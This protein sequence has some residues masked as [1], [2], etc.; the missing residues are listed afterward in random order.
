MAK[1]DR[2]P[3][4]A[5]EF[6]RMR[7][8]VGVLMGERG[9]DR[10]ARM[11]DLR[12]AIDTLARRIGTTSGGNL[13]MSPLANTPYPTEEQ[14]AVKLATDVQAF[15]Y[16]SG[17]NL[18]TSGS[19]STQ[20]TFTA[21]VTGLRFPY[22]TWLVT[23]VDG[24]ESIVQASAS[25]E[26]VFTPPSSVSGPG[27]MTVRVIVSLDKGD[28]TPLA[29]DFMSV[30]LLREGTGVGAITM[31]LS[32]QAHVCPSA[33]D[34]SGVILTGSGT[35]LF[36]WS[37]VTPLAY[38]GTGAAN[39]TWRVTSVSVVSG[40]A[41]VDTT[42]TD[43]GDYARFGDA[44]AL[45]SDVAKVRYTVAGTDPAGLA[46]SGLSIEATLAKA[47]AGEDG[48]VG[49]TGDTVHTGR[50]YYQ[51]LQSFS[52]GTPSA[53]SY[54]ESTG[55]FSGL[56]SGWDEAQPQVDLTDT[57]VQEWSSAYVVRVDGE[58]GAQTISFSSPIG[59][60]QVTARIQSDNYD[61]SGDGGTLGTAGWS[62]D[63]DTG[64]AE[65]GSAAI[66]GQ[67]FAGQIRLNTAVLTDDG[68]G[69]ITVEDGGITTTLVAPGA[70]TD[71]DFDEQTT[72]TSATGGVFTNF[73]SCT[74]TLNATGYLVIMW[75]MAH[76]YPSGSGPSWGYRLRTTTS[77]II[78][79][80]GM[81][82]MNDFP[83][84]SY[85]VTPL[86]AGTYTVFLDWKATNNG[87][88][89]EGRGWLALIGVS[90]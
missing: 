85:G 66:R 72:M 21:T 87:A 69:N 39:G 6:N 90:R 64:F 23:D 38:D 81:A 40:S 15:A 24:T 29:E 67:L 44:S 35:D 55:T 37:G 83:S 13:R 3:L 9:E 89:I 41:T 31:L 49:V 75:G 46:F 76:G 12:K 22:Y 54:N 51:T 48:A 65:F 1:D 58:T 47:K 33:N 86:E 11:S 56:S 73:A 17:G 74:V 70:I 20:G 16:D 60:I 2:L 14:V 45:T 4:S 68:L 71:F 10:A 7:E 52:P 32:N 5:P 79:R 19:A 43:M 61:G 82:A 78:E 57:S 88:V 77:T 36:V 42:P 34:G 28:G 26:F 84:S 62:I 30:A 8:S 53:S 25:N 80:T 50:V 18:I 27:T 63:R 59:A